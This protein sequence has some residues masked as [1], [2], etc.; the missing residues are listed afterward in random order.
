MFNQKEWYKRNRER[1]L[2]Y[3][4]TWQKTEEGKLSRKKSRKKYYEKNKEYINSNQKEWQKT[5]KGKVSQKKSEEKWLN[6]N[7]EYRKKRYEENK[8]RIS[9]KRMMWIKTNKGRAYLQ[10]NNIVRRTNKENI[11]NTLT[12]NEWLDILETY[13]Y[14]CAYCGIDFDENTLPV[15]DHVIPISKGGDNTKENVV[16]SCVICNSKK[17]NRILTGGVYAN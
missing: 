14:R 15:R 5:E 16:P 8:E 1:L 11:I 3:Q 17:G 6:K 10:R 2:E 13:N 9:R 12:S 7:P 4:K